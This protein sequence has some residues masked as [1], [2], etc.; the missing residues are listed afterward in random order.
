MAFIEKKVKKPTTY[1]E[2]LK[3]SDVT[4]LAEEM[5]I[6]NK[7][8]LVFAIVYYKTILGEKPGATL[9][10]AMLDKD[11]F[12]VPDIICILDTLRI[13]K[14][15][16]TNFR[17]MC[18]NEVYVSKEIIT[19][20]QKGKKITQNPAD[21]TNDEITD[22]LTNAISSLW[23]DYSDFAEF[24]DELS[25]LIEA[26]PNYPVFTFL[27]ENKIPEIEHYFFLY[28]FLRQLRMGQSS[29]L[30]DALRHLYPLSRDKMEL[31]KKYFSGEAFLLKKGFVELECNELISSG[32]YVLKNHVFEDLLGADYAFTLDKNKLPGNTLGLELSE[33]FNERELFFNSE[34]EKKMKEI[35]ELIEHDHFAQIKTRFLEGK[36]KSGICILLYGNPGTGKT[37]SVLQLAKST[38]RNI[39]RADISQLKDKYV[40]ESEKK[41][42]ELFARYRKLCKTQETEPILLLNE[43]DSIIGRRTVVNN[44]IDQMYNTMQ[45]ILL[46]EMESFEGILIAT[47]NLIQNMDKAFERRFLYKIEL[48]YP[49][50]DVRFKIWRS[51]LSEMDETVLKKIAENYNL[52]GG[53]IDNV[54][55]KF[56]MNRLLKGANY[57]E[58][59]LRPFCEEES[60]QFNNKNIG[61]I[62]F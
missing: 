30:E 61:K 15:I 20:L 59:T 58:D 56:L 36:C 19:K 51:V 42:R 18:S 25:T 11:P 27:N 53:Q 60:F 17:S 43:A 14:L 41:I 26:Y 35:S 40:G 55:R 8:A 33:Q 3:L 24:E 49:E 39:L 21:I 1:D 38:H 2:K 32:I 45:N 48:K 47:S 31:R 9:I 46:E 16:T 22:Q 12:I 44:N 54:V 37:E 57:S 29:N 23:N 52:S 28:M 4:N 13:K 34:E 7:E 6:S 5:Q 10:G 62:G 50:A